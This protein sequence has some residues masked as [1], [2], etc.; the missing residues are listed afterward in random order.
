MSNSK[1]V[2]STEILGA[3]TSGFS[4]EDLNAFKADPKGTIFA[5]TN[6][7]IGGYELNIN[8]AE[9][10]A[11]EVHIALPYYKD[12]DNLTS[13]MIS[14]ADLSEISGGELPMAIGGI[15]S[16]LIVVGIGFG[17]ASGVAAAAAVTASVGVG[18]T[19]AV[20][21]SEG[22]KLDGKKK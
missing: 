3:L 10:S 8:L 19:A 12:L 11:N 21:N 20:Y 17:I 1:I 2:A 15:V 13:E 16:T 5:K 7:D 14:D 6:A 9:N 18:I 22:K 4:A